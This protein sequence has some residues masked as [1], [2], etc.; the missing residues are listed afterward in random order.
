M[1][2]SGLTEYSRRE[3]MEPKAKMMWQLIRSSKNTYDCG[4]PMP[5]TLGQN[6][7]QC[8]HMA[9][10]LGPWLKTG[11]PTAPNYGAQVSQGGDSE[12]A[13]WRKFV[14]NGGSSCVVGFGPLLICVDEDLWLLKCRETGGQRMGSGRCFL[15]CNGTLPSGSGGLEA[16]YNSMPP[17]EEQVS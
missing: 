8:M 12:C 2:K 5:Q 10:R 14:E 4:Q 16:I 7:V 3:E 6:L 11:C 13:T 1:H 17:H 15:P 9:C